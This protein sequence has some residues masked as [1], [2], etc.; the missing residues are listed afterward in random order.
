MRLLKWQK[1]CL[2]KEF[3][4]YLLDVYPKHARRYSTQGYTEILDLR[5]DALVNR[6]GGGGVDQEQSGWKHTDKPRFRGQCLR[7]FNSNIND[8]EADNFHRDVI[9]GRNALWSYMGSSF[10][11]WDTGSTLLFWRW[12]RQHR[13]LVR[14]GL[15]PYY[16]HHLPQNQN[17]A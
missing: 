13:I 8:D 14:D 16:V 9:A 3:L 1:R 15:K 2:R 17:K 4:L 11:N 5:T 10:F 12:P 7:L 6:G